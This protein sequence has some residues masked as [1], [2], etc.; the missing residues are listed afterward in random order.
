M[1]LKAPFK[2]ERLNQIWRVIIILTAPIWGPLWFVACIAIL[3]LVFVLGY[4]AALFEGSYKFIRYGKW[5]SRIA[6]ELNL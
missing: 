3:V 1:K 2:N 4:P 5:E 6:E